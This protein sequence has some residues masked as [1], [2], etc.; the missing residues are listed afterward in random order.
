MAFTN[1][2]QQLM[3]HFFDIFES[4]TKNKKGKL[5]GNK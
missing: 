5:Q 3:T 4:Y 1:R 2:S